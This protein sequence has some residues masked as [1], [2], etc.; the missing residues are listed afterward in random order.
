MLVRLSHPYDSLQ[1]NLVQV[2]STALSASENTELRLTLLGLVEFMEHEDKALP[3]DNH[4]LG[5]IAVRA[6]AFAK[7]LHYKEFEFFSHPGAKVVEHLLG[8][9]TKLQQKDAAL[10][11]L[12]NN[13]SKD[14][15]PVLWYEQ[16]GRWQDALDLYL[17]R[18]EQHPSSYSQEA[19][20]G[21]L[22]CLHA[23]GEWDDLSRAIDVE[24]SRST[25]DDRR[26]LAPMA[27]AAAWVLRRWDD[28][29]EFVTTMAPESPD[30]S[31]YRAILSVHRNQFD[32][33]ATCIALARDSLQTDMSIVEDYSRVYK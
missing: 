8:I 1:E 20:I 2:I 21:R 33:A 29:D 23:L 19:E 13:L 30:R 14:I 3:I 16:L 28:M 4:T 22:R 17:A 12:N 31:F 24:W 18:I 7:A 5:D 9:N 10:G 6:N 26:E 15:E 27:A 32:T 11:L 25:T